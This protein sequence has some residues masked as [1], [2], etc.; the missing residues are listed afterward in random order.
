[1]GVRESILDHAVAAVA[2]GGE[3]SLRVHDIA[4]QVGC[5]VSALYVHFGSREGLAEAALIE[6]CRREVSRIDEPLV[7]DLP[8]ATS[9]SA[10]KRAISTHVRALCSPEQVSIHQARTELVAA[11]HRRPTAREALVEIE[12]QRHVGLVAAFREARARGVVRRDVDPDG[13]ATLV[14][15]GSLSVAMVTAHGE[16]LSGSWPKVLQRSLEGLLL[17]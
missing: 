15:S 8:R 7:T 11:A 4:R 10:V 6:N 12:Q 3:S 5:S 13:A 2:S 16:G 17:P 1:M 9:V 14:R